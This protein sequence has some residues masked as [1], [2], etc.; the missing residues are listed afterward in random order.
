MHI[1]ILI[2]IFGQ[3]SYWFSINNFK[4]KPMKSI[5]ILSGSLSFFCVL[6]MLGI[7]SFGQVITVNIDFS[8]CPGNINAGT[9]PAI[10]NYSA[11]AICSPTPDLT[12]TFSGA[13][14]GSGTGTGSGSMFNAGTTNVTITATNIF[15]TATC[16]FDVIIYDTVPPEIVCPGDQTIH[17]SDY[18]YTLPYA[19]DNCGN[20]G[21]YR[22]SDC[23]FDPFPMNNPT[24]IGNYYSNSIDNVPLPFQFKYFGIPHTSV[25]VSS[26][27]FLSF[28]A[29]PGVGDGCCSAQPIPNS[30]FEN[31]IAATWCDLQ[32]IRYYDTFGVAPNRIF[33]VYW[34]GFL[35]NNY[36]NHN[37]YDV[38][39]QV[40]LYEESN[41][42]KIISKINN[43]YN[44]DFTSKTMG[45]N[46]DGTTSLPVL[47][48]N[49]SNWSASN[50]CISFIPSLP[51]TLISG[52]ASG[53]DF[54]PGTSSVIY[55]ATDNNGNT[56]TCSFNITYVPFL[57]GIVTVGDNGNYPNLTGTGGLFEAINN[58]GICGTLEALIISDI[59][60]PGT[61]AL[62]E[63]NY[64]KP[65]L[66]RL[67]IHPDNTQ[68][69]RIYGNVNQAMLRF[70]NA[71]FVELSGADNSYWWHILLSIVNEDTTQPV[72]EFKNGSSNNN[73]NGCHLLSGNKNPSG[74][75][76]VLGS[77][78]NNEGNSHNLF[79]NNKFNKS[80]VNN[81]YPSNMVYS[82]GNN[83]APNEFNYF[84]M[85]QFVDF[86]QKGILVTSTGN[87]SGWLI[88]D[89]L[90]YFDYS[91]VVNA[92]KIFIDFEPGLNSSD[93]VIS[94]NRIGGI[95]PENTLMTCSGTGYL[96]GI[97][98]NSDSTEIRS[99]VIKNILLS[100]KG[101]TNLTGI[102]ISGDENT[103]LNNSF[104]VSDSPG[105][106]S[107]TVDGTG[108]II[109]IIS[110]T[111]LTTNI[112]N[113]YLSDILFTKTSGSPIFKG[114]QIKNG[115]VFNNSIKNIS[116][117]QT[118]ISPVIYGI[119]NAGFGL[120]TYNNIFNNMI[121]INSGSSSKPKV[122]GLYD[123]SAGYGANFYSNS[124]YISGKSTNGYFTAA[125]Y[126]NGSA[127]TILYNN[128]LV[129]GRVSNVVAKHYAVYT[130]S[131]SNWMVSDHND[132]Y[133]ASNSLGA[134][135]GIAC[136]T[137]AAWKKITQQDANSLNI[138][139]VFN[140]A[141]DLHLIPAM[142]PDI[143]NA[144]GPKY[145]TTYD[146][147]WESRNHNTPTIGCDEIQLVKNISI[148]D[149]I[150][151]PDNSLSSDKNNMVVFPNPAAGNATININLTNDNSITVEM[152]NMLGLK[153]LDI[154]KGNYAAGSFNLSI[155]ISYM[156]SGTY[157]IRYVV[158]N[159]ESIIKR[160]E[161]IK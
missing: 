30:N 117:S 72:I 46:L 81:I 142:N 68:Y 154:A 147:D 55:A 79:I 144:G 118:H 153:I 145:V 39:I 115:R 123:Q 33:V 35:N 91:P 78:D 134:Y 12:Y 57:N 125:F 70:D 88:L 84:F 102:E 64:T 22:V 158:N 77:T 44:I 14:T 37:E 4:S 138:M 43:D 60:E 128:I 61:F 24:I 124:V 100:N 54:P 41:E 45:L 50:E 109:G 5:K 97:L 8:D 6:V 133:T 25:Y 111:T 99:N 131:N 116:T 10:V 34:Q 48:R 52:I 119:Y 113:N 122:Y 152:Y 130:N 49:A 26:F 42:I 159:S 69:R 32:A 53:D 21:Y 7:P 137:L 2:F 74:G 157:I 143:A 127:K 36:F 75:V 160:I 65:G 20:D 139:P 51:V 16:I 110:T 71:D 107:I 87:G 120:S 129:N 86:D 148:V 11:T 106:P 82:S 151:S 101:I 126:R 29:I 58:D 76:F 98:V 146:F 85:N 63:I 23:I 150:T 3:I 67:Y 103:V 108:T 104:G 38:Q 18:G 93:N 80:Y 40:A 15:D 141:D 132:L 112:R 161:I 73:I 92:N 66:D 155:D 105:S 136:A 140:S 9:C 27:G 83:N 31:S 28:D 1:K 114:I 19:T 47:G 95:Y 17:C 62:N 135:G 149:N 90:F 89:N 59:E 13:T 56:S 121:A 156:P 96:K 94:N